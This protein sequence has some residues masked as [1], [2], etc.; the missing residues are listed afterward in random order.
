VI[1]AGGIAL[2]VALA[3]SRYVYDNDKALHPDLQKI[4]AVVGVRPAPMWAG[5][6]KQS[7]MIAR[8]GLAQQNVPGLSVAVGIG[9]DIVWSEGFGWTDL[10]SHAP[11]TPDSQFRIG[12]VS[13]A[14]TSAGV[15]RLVEQ[16]RLRFD[17]EIQDRVPG[18][19]KKQWPVTLR[20]LMGN[21]AGVRHY[22]DDEWGDKPSATCAR[23]SDGLP[24]F[25]NDPLLFEPESQYRYSTYGWVLVSA[26]AEAAAG[27]P[28]FEFMR[29][30]VLEPLGMSHTRPDSTR[31]MIPDRVTSYFR[32][33]LGNAISTGVDY[34]C[35]A[36]GGA[37]LSTPS[38]LVK[39]GMALKRGA[40][41]KPD[42][43]KRLQTRQQ[44]TSGQETDYGLGW[45]LDTVQLAGQRTLAAG[46]SSRTLEG[47][48]T[49]F[50]M[51]PERDLVVAVTSN[52]SF[53]DMRSI[54]LAIAQVF[55]SSSSSPPAPASSPAR[56]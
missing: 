4:S 1:I 6:V 13:N 3:L 10:T 17:D 9:T 2:T 38:D 45:M 25:A 53:A 39:F 37:F 42:S 16:G 23:A 19:P 8:Q 50:L 32:G 48:S 55:A 46:H 26:A 35:F 12:H 52:M 33:N 27:E 15:A 40:L 18:Y 29:T 51:F 43:L 54:A 5:A 20:Q 28:F 36:G 24:S 31:E 14:L 44:L 34:S 7:R 21:V 56:Q 41:L 47:A 49:S 22:R 11:V 30:Q